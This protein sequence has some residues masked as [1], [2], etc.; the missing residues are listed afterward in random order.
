[1][2]RKPKR[3]VDEAG[4]LPLFDPAS[5]VGDRDG[6]E[7][8]VVGDGGLGGAMGVKD[9]SAAWGTEAA[10]RGAGNRDMSG[11]RPKR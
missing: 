8:E 1:M 4:L 7:N 9:M 5:V 11:T 6:E 3:S 10:V 2:T